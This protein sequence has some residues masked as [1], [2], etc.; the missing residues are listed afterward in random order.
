MHK[1]S[2][3]IWYIVNRSL[4]IIDALTLTANEKYVLIG[5][6]PACKWTPN[7]ELGLCKNI[8][9]AS[10]QITGDQAVILSTSENC[11]IYRDIA[12]LSFWERWQ[13]QT[14]GTGIRNK[15]QVSIVKYIDSNLPGNNA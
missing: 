1:Y 3:H 7:N 10:R 12:F 8:G 9:C 11:Y 6:V 5:N 2:R 4:T 15:W 14:L 13:I